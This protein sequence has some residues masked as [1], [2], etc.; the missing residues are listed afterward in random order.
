M[1]TYILYQPIKT[2]DGKICEEF[3]ITLDKGKAILKI[4]D[5]KYDELVCSYDIEK[6]VENISKKMLNLLLNY[7]IKESEKRK[8]QYFKHIELLRNNF[9]IGHF[10]NVVY[11]NE[12]KISPFDTIG[13]DVL[14]E[15]DNL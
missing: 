13:C 5:V 8:A 2:S 15:K 12:K 14:L 9:N 6:E 3:T 1:T 11:K 7:S 4:D 10:T